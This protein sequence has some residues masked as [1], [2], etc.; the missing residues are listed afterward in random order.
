MNPLIGQRLL[1]VLVSTDKAAILFETEAGMVE[2]KANG[3][4]CSHSWIESVESPAHALGGVVTEVEDLDMPDQQGG[5]RGDQE[6]L[7]FYGCKI[8]TD[9]G[10]FTID[11]RNSSNGYYGGSLEWDPTRY[12]G[13]VYGQNN[14]DPET[15]W[16]EVK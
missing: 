1:K 10:S 6:C 8:T 15:G 7:K 11:Y 5:D 12:Y 2:A 3:D 4:C 13:G 16:E 14:R 9:K